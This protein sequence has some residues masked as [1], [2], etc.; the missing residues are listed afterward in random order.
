MPMVAC[1]SR[2][3]EG[4]KPDTPQ[5][6]LVRIGTV[7]VGT[8][9]KKTGDVTDMVARWRLDFCCVQETR[10]KG[11]SVRTMG[12]KGERYKFF[13]AGSDQRGF[14]GVGILVAERWIDKVIEVKR[15]SERVMVLRVRMGKTVM[16]LVSAYAPQAGRGIEEKE[17]FYA[18][19]CD[20][21]AGID[22]REELV[23]CGDM[24]GHTGKKVDGFEGVHGG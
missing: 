14:A 22:P 10:W 24:N 5:G 21:L 23:V 16:N 3:Y 17:E 2:T 20:V 8:M 9:S 19:M 7:N 6:R 18:L 4:Q 12:K 15:V 11:G 13:W 1:P